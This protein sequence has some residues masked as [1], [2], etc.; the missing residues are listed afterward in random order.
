MRQN[1]S[2]KWCQPLECLTYIERGIRSV[3][4]GNIGSVGQ[5]AAKLL[6]FN[7]GG[8]PK[9]SAAFSHF[10]LSVCKCVWPRFDSTV[11]G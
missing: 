7:V 1:L 6:D 10:S 9:K 8:P 2:L 4:T 3:H 5:R 11:W